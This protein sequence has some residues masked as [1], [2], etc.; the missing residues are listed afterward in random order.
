MRAIYKRELRACFN[1]FIGWLFLAVVLFLTG[2]YTTVYNLLQGSV[3]LADTLISC[4]ILFMMAIPVL[5]MRIFS[6]ERKNKTDQLILTAPVGIWKVV[7]GKYLALETVFA[8]PCAVLALYPLFLGRYGTIPYVENYVALLG[9]F[10]YGSAVVAIGVFVSSLT[11]SQVIAAVLTVVFVFV[12]SIMAGLCSLI[13]RSGNMLTKILGV[14]DFNTPFVDLLNGNLKIAAI[15]YYLSL[16]FLFLFF[17]TQSIQKRRYSV[18]VKQLK[19]GAYSIGLIA[20]TTAVVICGNLLLRKVPAAY[21]EFDV[22]R[23]RL[24]SLTE[25]SYK[26]MDGLQENITIY[27]LSTESSMSQDVVQMLKRYEDYS[28][29]QIQVEYVDTSANPTFAN[30]YTD[31][32]LS[33][34][35]LIVAGEKRSKC[36]DYTELY[37]SELSYETFAYETTGFDAEGQIT[38]ALNYVTMEDMPK[39]YLLTGHGEISLEEG[40]LSVLSKLNIEYETL[41]L[42][43]VDAVPEDAKGL[44]VNAPGKDFSADDTEKIKAYLDSGKNALFVYGYS[45]EALPNYRSLFADYHV[46]IADGLVVEQNMNYYYQNNVLWL[47]PEV[48]RDELTESVYGMYVFAPNACGIVIDEQAEENGTVHYLLRTTE[49]AFVRGNPEEVSAGEKME[50]D[51]DGPFALGVRATRQ[52]EEG[53]STIA[54]YTSGELFSEVVDERVA[55]NNKKL[56]EGTVRGFGAVENN[57]TI[58]AKSYYAGL[59]TVSMMDVL[60][61]GLVMSLALPLMLIVV[62]FV[63]W[64]QR[65]KR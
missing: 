17:T 22:T 54:V 21:T 30:Q 53:E 33:P 43:T 49:E 10:L 29:K 5:T 27:V 28:K 45:E 37:L 55:G 13:S 64:L 1:S 12:G 35:S 34:G 18:S 40:F 25:D 20:L 62:G 59:L 65:R 3:Y 38:S 32:S 56:F 48:E 47:L 42:L 19:R 50:G 2:L 57:V 15:L 4:R 63:I 58:P 9:F 51:I 23:E 14:Y 31:V 39:V 36:I 24:Y 60:L 26:V 46:T 6:E 7:L 41:N 11:E 61:V 44:I 8:L 52:T 16:I